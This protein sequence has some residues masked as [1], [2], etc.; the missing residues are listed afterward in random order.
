MSSQ[1]Y[2][3][4][5]YRD[6]DVWAAW[7]RGKFECQDHPNEEGRSKKRREVWTSSRKRGYEIEIKADFC[8]S[9]AIAVQVR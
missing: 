5:D 9:N 8:I 6:V 1:R 7:V 2:E 3:I 4:C